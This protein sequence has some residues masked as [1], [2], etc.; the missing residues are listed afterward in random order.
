MVFDPNNPPTGSTDDEEAGPQYIGVPTG[1]KAQVPGA[2][3]YFF[4]PATMGEDAAPVKYTSAP[5]LVDPIY[6]IGSEN[7]PGGWGEERIVELQSQLVDAGILK[8]NA[9]Q[10]GVWDPA[11]AAAYERLLGTANSAGLN[12][13]QVLSNYRQVIAKYGRPE[14]QESPRQPLITQRHDPEALRQLLGQVATRT[15]FGPITREQEDQFIAAFNGLSDEAQKA[16]YVAE[17]SGAPGGPGGIDQSIDPQA[18]ASKFVREQN[19]Q[20]VREADVAERF[21]QF[22]QLLGKYT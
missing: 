18:Q 16:K 11:S 19:P 20:G 21:D 22:Q 13:D 10:R 2:S 1:Y 3:K 5:T 9:Y 12:A 6:K 8:R 14:D 7:I 17:G 15:A 4:D